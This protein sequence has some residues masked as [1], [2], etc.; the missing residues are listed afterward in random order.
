MAN[1]LQMHTAL[2]E[3]QLGAVKLWLEEKEKMRDAY[4]QDD[5]VRGKGI[6]DIMARAVAATERYQK[7]ERTVDIEGVGLEALIHADLTQTGGL[8][9]LQMCQQL[10]P[11]RQLKSMPMPKLKP[12]RTPKPNPSPAPQPAAT[13]TPSSTLAPK[14]GTLLMPTPSR[15]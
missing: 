10:Q 13:P 5:L 11:E 7:E 8:E 9:K 12:K 14:G 15:R 2:Q 4:H 1:M 3:A 6:T